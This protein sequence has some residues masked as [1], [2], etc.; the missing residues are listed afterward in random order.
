MIFWIIVGFIFA[1]TFSSDVYVFLNQLYFAGFRYEWLQY[2]SFLFLNE[3]F[4]SVVIVGSPFHAI[5]IYCAVQN[6]R[7]NQ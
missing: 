5:G 7:A 4:W 6:G 2:L 1:K 3:G